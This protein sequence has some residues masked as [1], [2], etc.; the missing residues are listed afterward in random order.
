MT[1]KIPWRKP[2]LWIWNKLGRIWHFII[3]TNWTWL[4]WLVGAAIIVALGLYVYVSFK[5]ESTPL[6]YHLFGLDSIKEKGTIFSNTSAP[7]VALGAAA[8]MFLSFWAQY[9]ANQRQWKWIKRQ[10]EEKKY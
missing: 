8:L 2:F 1:K 6:L 5:P 10:E 3:E 7:I 4:L 9:Q